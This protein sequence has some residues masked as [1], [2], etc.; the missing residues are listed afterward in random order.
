LLLDQ[1]NLVVVRPP[2]ETLLAKSYPFPASATSL[3]ISEEVPLRAQSERLQISLLFLSGTTELFKGDSLVEVQSGAP[4]GDPIPL[5]VGYVGPGQEVTTLRLAPR[6][7]VLSFGATLAFRATAFDAQGA[8]VPDFYLSWQSSDP[9]WRPDPAGVLAAGNT[10]GT[11]RITAVTPRGISDF[12]SVTVTAPPAQLAKT[13][14]DAQS[15]PISGRLPLPLEVEV[16]GSDDLPV[17]GT[18]V[19]FAPAGGGSVDSG[20]T[21]TDVNGRARTG[22]I[23]G[24]AVGQQNFTATVAGVGSVSFSAT[25]SQPAVAFATASQAVAESDGT[26]IIPVQL[27]GV[28]ALPVT[29]PFSLSG[30]A[31]SPADYTVTSPLVIPAGSSG[32]GITVSLSA[33]GIAEPDETVILTLG[34]PTNATLGAITAHTVTILAQRPTVSFTSANQTVTES[35]GAATITAQLSGPSTS[36]V[37][38]PFTV[39]GTA[40]AGTDYTITA[41]PLVIPAGST[42]GSVT[43]SLAADGVAE[44][45]ETVIV[46]L[47]TP[48]NAVPGATTVHTLTIAG[49]TPSVSFATASQTVSEGVGSST[50]VVQLSSPSVQPV[51]IPFTLGGSATTPADYGI[52]ASPLTIPAG[53]TSGTLTVTVVADALA[54]ANETIIVTLGTPTNATLGTPT[55]HTVTI[56]GQVPAVSLVATGQAVNEAVGSTTIAAQLSIPSTS[57]VTVPFTVSGT[58]A[59]P[60]DYTISASPLTIPAGSTS[61]AITVTVVADGVAEPDE[62]IIVTLGTPTNATLGTIT[63]HTVTILAQQPSVSFTAATQTVGEGAGA[64]TI[65]AQLSGPST[66]PVTLPFTVA[67]TATAGTDYTITASPLVIPAGGTGA[68]ITVTLVNDALAEPDETVIV[69]LGT[70]SNATLGATTQHTLTIA[71]NDFTLAVVLGGRGAGTVATAPGFTPAINCTTGGPPAQCAATYQAGTQVSLLATPVPT[72][73]GTNRFEGWSGTGTGFTC[74]TSTTC[75][76]S[77]DQARQVTARFSIPGTITFVPTS[78]G[79]TMPE[80]GAPPAATTVS[81]TNTGERQLLLDPTIPVSYFD[82]VPAWLGVQIDRLVVDTLA[83][84]TLRLTVLPAA[85]GLVFGTYLADVIVRDAGLQ[86]AWVLPVTLTVTPPP[87]APTISNIAVSLI[88]LNDAQRCTLSTPAAS[89]FRITFDYTDPNGNGPTNISQAGLNI[90]WVFRPLLDTGGFNNYTFQS[91]LT[92][93]GFTGSAIT[94]QCY[95]FGSNTSVD[96]TMTI[97]DQGGLRSVGATTTI[98]KPPGSN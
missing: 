31:S 90:S 26:A 53:S 40:T 6:D 89:S 41:S 64:A 10:R 75:I 30:T 88:Q 69:T 39:A 74:T 33:D 2:A 96:V 61:G 38:L 21:T 15:G 82:E 4:R 48:T 73:E 81:V 19:A 18:R 35:A 62:T 85:S 45:D 70:P 84:A 16:R 67:G 83:P 87:T 76:V 77:M 65:T 32:A 20:S 22:A 13:G 79:F 57:P 50:I 25:A 9:L 11:F 14:G 97:Q 59:S 80:R 54:E 94:T 12:T 3:P 95:R 44:P 86:L 34:T 55:V 17:A 91:S 58:A 68:S 46:T 7:T 37:T 49:Q 1:V 78:A 93:N 63:V 43:V 52:N 66:S 98:L 72:A 23:L 92:G 8:P 27:S 56:A 28:T 71:D 29:V 5:R 36:P 42:S 51:T 24:P 47:G 60:A